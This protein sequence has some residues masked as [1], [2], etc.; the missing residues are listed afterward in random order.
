MGKKS[1][2]EKKS[3]HAKKSKKSKH[4]NDD[5]ASSDS[6]ASDD[7]RS[8]RTQDVEAEEEE[9]E[10]VEKPVVIPTE[11]ESLSGPTM[12]ETAQPS[13]QAD[14]MIRDDWMLRPPP[15]Q[16]R[17]MPKEEKVDP[18]EIERQR[19][20]AIRSERELNP[21]FANGGAGLPP[22]SASIEPS[23]PKKG[24]EFG[25]KGSNWRMMKL[26]RVKEIAERE[27]KRVE[28]VG[29]ERFGSLEE[30]EFAVAERDYLD[31]KRSKHSSQGSERAAATTEKYGR[32][33]KKPEEDGDVDEFGRTRRVPP[34][35]PDP[36]TKSQSTSDSKESASKDTPL[37]SSTR[38]PITSSIPL[39]A[40][41][42]IPT[43]Q[44]SAEPILSKDELNK[45]NARILKA[46]L[47]GQEPDPDLVN[48]YEREKARSEAHAQSG[49]GVG[50]DVVMLS[51]IDSRGRL[52]DIG[53]GQKAL[54]PGNKRKREDKETFDEKGQRVKYLGDNG[55]DQTLS[56]LILQEKMSTSA[57][58]DS[59]YARRIA[60]DVTYKADLDY[61]DDRAEQLAM[62]RGASEARKR[63]VAVMDYKRA[64]TAQAK[65]HHCWQGPQPPK[66]TIL[67]V[68][69][70][71]YLGLPSHVQMVQDHCYIIPIQHT[72]TS[73]ECE[74]DA[75]DEIRNYMK[76]LI[77]MQWQRNHGVIF[78]EQVLNLKWQKHTVIEC[79]PVPLSVFDEAKAYFHQAL[80]T[81]DDEWSTHKKIIQTESRGFRRSMVP[82]LP[83]FHVWFNP[84][85]G[86]GHVIEGEGWAEWFGREVVGGLLG[87][88]EG[89]L[90]KWR[91]PRKAGVEEVRRAKEGFQGRWEKFDWTKMLN[92]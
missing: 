66:T 10:W 40:V 62:Q 3:K 12:M 36:S 76:C 74:D 27:G 84:D 64:Q 25:D 82:H 53:S 44:I 57:D 54:L 24:P 87:M 50:E 1:K 32:G 14:K 9:D 35:K 47:L 68:G 46:K 17:A 39:L 37:K 33:F 29:I 43:P 28:E 55:Q 83:Y 89:D 7:H 80:S 41:P 5:G 21:H 65:C 77:Q 31:G 90:G 63:D 69:N 88:D 92:E 48:L 8:K 75:W 34:Q 78:I 13:N 52:Q 26:K 85:G 11:Q 4:H 72:L 86:F 45:L 79:I 51:A 16:V 58:Y 81:S 71:V 22:S 56:D 6:S 42:S 23:E 15:S 20:E 91:R 70:K 60:G 61:M 73:L 18:K 30:Y 38:V 49:G 59:Q 67:S 19:K 2:K